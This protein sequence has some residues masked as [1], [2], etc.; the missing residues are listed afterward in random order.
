MPVVRAGVAVQHRQP[1]G[2]DGEVGLAVAP[3]PAHGVGDHHADRHPEAIAQPEAQRRGTGVGVDRQQRQLGRADV[4]A[5][6]SG[7]RLDEPER[8]L[9]DQGA[10][11]ARQHPYGFG[12]DELAPQRIPLIGI[13]GCLDDAALALGHHLAGDHYHV[14]VTQPRRRRGD[15]GGEVVPWPKLRQ[16]GYRKYLDGRCAAVVAAGVGHRRGPGLKPARSRPARTISAVVGGSVISSGTA[17]TSRSSM[18]A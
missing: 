2:A 18:S 10:A 8:V 12:I 16:P 11:L 17:R 3:G 4:G 7:G 1:R 13:L 15:G 9:G 5:V 14:V 6:H